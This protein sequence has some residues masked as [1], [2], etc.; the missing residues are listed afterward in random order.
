M[1]YI[2]LTTLGL[3][4]L[5]V[6]F[7]A[8]A[9]H[10]FPNPY[11]G[12]STAFALQ[13]QPKTIAMQCATDLGFE[14]VAA[15]GGGA[16]ASGE[17]TCQFNMTFGGTEEDRAALMLALEQ[18]LDAAML[19][20][21]LEIRSRGRWS[22]LPGFSRRYRSLQMR[23]HLSVYSAVAADNFIYVRGELTEVPR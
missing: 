19:E 2:P 5:L 17:A 12:E 18:R 10:N 14:L 15:G 21:G 7:T 23:G 8:C 22:G 6:M 9:T 11:H 13:L 4:A 1:R 3:L 20:Q 16:H